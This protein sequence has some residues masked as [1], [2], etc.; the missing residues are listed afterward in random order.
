MEVTQE[1]SPANNLAHG[2]KTVG[3]AAVSLCNR[4]KTNRGVLV[5]ADDGNSAKVW[6]GGRAVT[7]NTDEGTGG[8]PLPAG[9]AIVIPIDDPSQLYVVSTSN[10]Q[11]VAW[12]GV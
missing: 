6:I 3:T 1:T 2:C 7:P 9:Q 12:M 8:L 4:F 10:G 11:H 5:R